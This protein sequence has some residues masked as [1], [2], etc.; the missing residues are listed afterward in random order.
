MPWDVMVSTLYRDGSCK[1]VIQFSCCNARAGNSFS[2][3]G[4][5]AFRKCSSNLLS[6]SAIRV[7]ETGVREQKTNKNAGGCTP[8]MHDWAWDSSYSLAP[9]RCFASMFRKYI[10]KRQYLG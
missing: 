3:A 2:H 4:C 8:M 9:W 7:L 6:H 1:V 10:H 5:Q